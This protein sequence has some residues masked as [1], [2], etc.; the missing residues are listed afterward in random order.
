MDWQARLDW[1]FSNGY[2]G[3]VGLEYRPTGATLD[4]FNFRQHL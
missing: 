2:E 1:L 4:S 3:L